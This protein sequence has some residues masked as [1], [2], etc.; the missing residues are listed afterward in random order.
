MKF[1]PGLSDRRAKMDIRRVGTTDGGVPIYT[2]KYVGDPVTRMGVM[3]DE[4]PNDVK[5]LGL[6]GLYR[7]YYDRVA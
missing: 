7:V 6:D 5:V 4:V 2:Y 1:L 3:A